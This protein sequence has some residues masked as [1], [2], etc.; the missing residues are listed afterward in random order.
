MHRQKSEKYLLNLEVF[1]RRELSALRFALWK[2]REDVLA[3]KMSNLNP[4]FQADM[5]DMLTISIR[6]LDEYANK[7]GYV[8]VDN[9]YEP[10]WNVKGGSKKRC[11]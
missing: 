11:Q 8:I 7:Q 4:C 1:E 10:K 9:V 3:G 6:E 5:R 2:K